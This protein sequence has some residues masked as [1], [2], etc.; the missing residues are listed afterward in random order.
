MGVIEGEVGS[1]GMEGTVL[2][3]GLCLRVRGSLSQATQQP[4]RGRGGETQ[5]VTCQRW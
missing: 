5:Y 3:I 1:N 4:A 2:R